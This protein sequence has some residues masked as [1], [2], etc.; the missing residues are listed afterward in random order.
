MKVRLHCLHGTLQSPAVWAGLERRLRGDSAGSI[1]VVAEAIVPPEEGGLA[2]WASDFCERVAREDAPERGAR[3]LLGYSLGGRLAMHALVCCPHL[4][5]SVILVA[6]HPGG[7]ADDEWT[8][9]RERDRA[10]AA[11]LRREP[12][13]T[14]LADWDGLPVFGGRP[15]AAP[16]PPDQMNRELQA[17]MFEAFSRSRQGDVREDLSKAALPPIL[18]LTGSDDARYGRIGD[19][20]AGR[21]PALRHEVIPNAGHRV[22]WDQPAAFASTVSSFLEAP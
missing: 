8:A 13:E 19:E 22:P 17:R 21:I 12:L 7:D 1:R 15:N 2:V 16:R 4:W 18:Y 11:R 3:A 6:A 10:W 20:L 9:I 14:V 5:S